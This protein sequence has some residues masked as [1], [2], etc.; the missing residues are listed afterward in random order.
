MKKLSLY[1]S[2]F[3]CIIALCAGGC[4]AR[5]KGTVLVVLSGADH[6]TLED[7]AKHPTGYFLSELMIPV[8]ALRKAGY[9]L[10]FANPTGVEPA[11]DKLSY[12]RILFDSE[13]EY[14]ES[15]RLEKTLPGLKAPR[16]L[17]S[18]S[19]DELKTFAGIFVPGGHAPMED[20][21]KD[22]EL[23]RILRHFHEAKKP[24]GLI[25]HGPIALLAAREGDDWPYK[26]YRVTVFSTA[27][28]KI[29]EDENAFGGK[30][31]FY[32]QDALAEVGAAVLTEE[33]P[34]QVNV[35]KDRELIT[36][37]NPMSSHRFA[38]V[39]VESLRQ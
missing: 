30:L 7:G 25:C 23:G 12:D 21:Y 26:G 9:A 32:P 8:M 5:S 35:I 27:E 15:M 17:S 24:T 2:L 4:K 33:K 1:V 11:V 14:Q 34:W 20:L 37:Q 36:G 6:L 31:R 38:D 13:E 29:G 28:E 10:V 16:T 3:L 39:F 22:N 18:I 19:D